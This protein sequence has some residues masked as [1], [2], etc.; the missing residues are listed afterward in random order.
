MKKEQIRVRKFYKEF[1]SWKAE[2]VGMWLGSIIIEVFFVVMAVIPYQEMKQDIWLV[3]LPMI[4][5]FAGGALYVAPY[6]TFFENQKSVSIYEKI[7][8]LPIDYQEVKKMRLEKLMIF[9][10]R[11]FLIV[12]VCN[13]FFSYFGFGAIAAEDVAYVVLIGLVCPI[14]SNLPYVWFSK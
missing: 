13:L 9:E 6:I 12:L 4:F 2:G 7:K 14:V 10:A 1:L 11:I 3:G 8:Y 5:G